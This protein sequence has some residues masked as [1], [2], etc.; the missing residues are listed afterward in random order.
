M[1]A[2]TKYLSATLL[3]VAWTARVLAGDQF[4][5]LDSD[6]A[7]VPGYVIYGNHLGSHWSGFDG[8]PASGG[9]VSIT[10]AV[11]GQT[12]AMIF[13]SVDL[14]TNPDSSVINVPIKA[15]KVE[16]DIRIGNPVGC[17]GRPADG[18]SISFA[19][20]PQD[21]VIFWTTNN[22]AGPQFR[23][24]AG[25]DGCAQATQL[26]SNPAGCDSGTAENGTKTGLAI[27]FDAWQ[28]NEL[29]NTAANANCVDDNDVEGIAIRVDD[30]TLIQVP[31][32]V[33]N[34]ACADTNS[35][36]TGPWDGAGAETGGYA[37]LC[38]AHVSAELDTNAQVTVIYK[39]RVMLDHYQLTNFP[40]PL[41]ARLILAGRTGGCNQNT[42]IDNIRIQTVAAIQATLDSVVGGVD[43]FS[44]NLKD[45]GPS[46][47]TNVTQVLLDNVDVTSQVVGS[48]SGNIFTVAYSQA[49]RFV[50]SSTHTL[51]VV[52]QDTVPQ[53]L[54][55]N[56]SFTVPNWIALPT[57]LALPLAQVDTSKPGFLV[58]SW[59]GHWPYAQPNQLAF[60]EEQILGYWG[61]NIATLAVPNGPDGLFIWDREINFSGGAGA[62]RFNTGENSFFNFG[63][64]DVTGNGNFDNNTLEFF[65]YV[66]FPTNGEY[67]MRAGSDDG[68][69]ISVGPQ[70]RDRMGLVVLSFNGGR[71]ISANQE[72]RSVLIDQA[73]VYPMRVLFENGGGGADLEWY[74]DFGNNNF[75]LV[76]DTNTV[77]S[78]RSYRELLPTANAGPYI[79]RAVPVRN[80]VWQSAYAPIII[81]IGDGVGTKTLNTGS[82]QLRVDGVL[83][84]VTTSTPSAGTTRVTRSGGTPYPGTHT[85]QLIY[86]DAAANNYTNTW[87]FTVPNSLNMTALQAS[88]SVPLSAVNLA[89]PGFRIFSYQ[90]DPAA[91]GVASPNTIGWLETQ[92]QGL[93][94][95][96]V[97]TQPSGSDYYTWATELNFD[98]LGG[99][100]FFRAIDN[101]MDAFGFQPVG[102]G[103]NR[104]NNTLV[105]GGWLV[106]SNA[107]NYVMRIT[108]D[109][110]F[111]VSSGHGNPFNP[112]AANISWFDGGRGSAGWNGGDWFTVMVPAAGAYPFRLLF[113]N[114]G[115]GFGVEWS[116]M[117]QLPDGTYKQVLINDPNE[118]GSIRA[119]QTTTQDSPLVKSINPP[120][121]FN[122]IPNAGYPGFP[123]INLRRT[124]D[125]S[126]N[127]EDADASTVNT[128]TIVLKLAGS[129]I[130]V[131]ITQ[132]TNGIV[133]NVFTHILASGAT[134][135]PSGARGK[136]ELTY[137]DNLGRTHSQS[138]DIISEFYGTLAGG[139]PLGSGDPTK[140]G[141]LMNMYQMHRLG[142]VN[143][144]NRYLSAEQELAGLLTNNIIP[145]GPGP[146]GAYVFTGVGENGTNALIN[147]N[148]DA[149]GNAGRFNAGNGRTDNRFP[150]MPVAGLPSGVNFDS[151][152][153]E[154]LTYVEF[155]SNGVYRLSVA[156]DDGFRLMRGHGRPAD[157]GQVI[158]N[159]PSALAGEKYAAPS[160]V[161]SPQVMSR[162][163]GDLVAALGFS[164]GSGL[165]SGSTDP[166]EGCGVTNGAAL[167]GKIALI[168]RGS[169]G[170]YEKVKRAQEAGAIAVLMVQN[171][172]VV[173][174]A[175][176]WFPI[177]VGVAPGN[178]QVALSIPAV[179]ISRA[180]GDALYAAIT[181]GTNVNLTL[182][183]MSLNYNPPA[184]NSPL[185][186]A[187]VGKGDSDVDFTVVVPEAGVYPLRLIWF[188]GGGGA[189]LEFSS[190]PDGT[191][192][193]L[194]NDDSAAVPALKAYW[195]VTATPSVSLT[196][197]GGS[198][199]ISNTGTLQSS[200]T[201]T[202]PY[203]D[204]YGNGPRTVS[205][206]SGPQRYWRSR[207]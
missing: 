116:V 79:K 8:N 144:P 62:G 172:P 115:G 174:P 54:T 40:T 7:A 159:S 63:Q 186:Q 26:A 13:P 166:R 198:L 153:A 37:N 43:R 17:G 194:V 44:V 3:G 87:Q 46:Q 169:C 101:T 193:V 81:D 28:G 137:Q 203:T 201:V 99:E 49:T 148:Q 131:S 15:F 66:Y 206:A 29:P 91:G 103:N 51:K 33:R 196:P 118:P 192:R 14:Y 76:N 78:I 142:G 73:G 98:D 75:V 152:G 10:D 82:I 24:F 50:A 171:R 32:A 199:V 117:Q 36:Q 102:G 68:Y 145:P 170:F 121:G 167:A 20:D 176:G 190:Y 11:N 57:S 104:N 16:A 151:F 149:P 64:Q 157:K 147:F 45:F 5:D 2:T 56:T 58:N 12:L 108:S 80:A 165:S 9:Y 188:E 138:W 127:L 31:M 189:N 35:V 125:I 182:T 160:S 124:A 178:N 47:V 183:P 135:W 120:P 34:G 55:F 156:S 97:A 140:R 59:Q 111:L 6:P 74:F 92:V 177:E 154:V 22:P 143:T 19:R 184:L 150:G 180:D 161:A 65:G 77:G 200:P 106:F 207:Q 85:I 42:H 52:V 187:D 168:Y 86:A 141:F 123:F 4:F 163:T 41:N 202:G 114:G 146:G 204:V 205:P 105:V 175:D 30:K 83:Q 158:I 130:P 132:D 195:G 162:I 155:P 38:W 61:T 122:V 109:D 107:G 93:Q 139:Y 96:N 191:T 179:M 18:F 134:G 84:S 129:V 90:T 23:A 164:D 94:G 72:F 95:P 100:G 71:G 70:S 21:P 48:R 126:V 89:Q 27:A 112:A 197:S 88:N 133:T 113:G 25:G 39:G 119:Y 60:T 53:T 185:G 1:K 136:L 69:Q 173:T 128:N 67:I 110:V 181:A